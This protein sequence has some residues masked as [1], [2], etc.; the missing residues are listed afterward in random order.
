[1][2]FMTALRQS[3]KSDQDALNS[4]KAPDQG[5]DVR[6]QIRTLKE[7]VVAAV[8]FPAI[9]IVLYILKVPEWEAFAIGCVAITLLVLY[10]LF[11]CGRKTYA[12]WQDEM[13]EYQQSDEPPLN[14]ALFV[15]DDVA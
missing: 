11:H 1:M 9:A 4:T 7:L 5:T 6:S 14:P 2:D 8:L 12:Q 10:I 15:V 13:L 3:Q